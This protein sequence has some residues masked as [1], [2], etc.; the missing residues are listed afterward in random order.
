MS[1]AL[2]MIILSVILAAVMFLLQLLFCFKAKGLAVKLIPVW[3]L[4]AVFLL[5]GLI[6]LG[7]FGTSSFGVLAG[8]QIAAYFAAFVT[9]IAALGAALAWVIYAFLHR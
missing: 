2:L 4:L 9:G 5:E 8:H 3:L 1:S 6:W 7:V